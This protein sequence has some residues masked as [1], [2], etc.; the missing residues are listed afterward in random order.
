MGYHGGTTDRIAASVEITSKHIC[1]VGCGWARNKK[2]AR[3]DS[4]LKLT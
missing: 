1:H 2:K 3:F 4:G